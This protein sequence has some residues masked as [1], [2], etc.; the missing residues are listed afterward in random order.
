MRIGSGKPSGKQFLPTAGWIVGVAGECRKTAGHS[1]G[2]RAGE[3]RGNRPRTSGKQHP[4]KG[5]LFPCLALVLASCA[6]SDE[7]RPTPTSVQRVITA[8]DLAVT[9]SSLR[10]EV[11]EREQERAVAE[12]QRVAE[13]ERRF[14][15]SR[16]ARRQQTSAPR[17]RP[18][19]GGGCERWRPL[20]AAHFPASAVDRAI[21]VCNCESGGNPTARNPRSTATGLFQILRGPVDPEANVALA[22]R[23]FRAR[24]W[25]PW[26]ACL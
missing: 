16:S 5:M 13:L 22:A 20:I 4:Y 19:R 26:K 10:A 1:P 7:S 9:V 8:D 24:G 17:V 25:Q 11:F 14:R 18:S 23:M 6:S 21:A 2:K 3:A 12:E 15:A